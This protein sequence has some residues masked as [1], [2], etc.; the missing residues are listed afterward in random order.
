MIGRFKMG[1]VVM[2]LVMGMALIF[3]WAPV[4]WALEKAPQEVL[5]ARRAALM[6]RVK[7]GALVVFAKKSSEMPDVDRSPFRQ[8]DDFYYLTGWDL[9]LIHI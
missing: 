8:D 2:S 6:E 4:A 1:R 5:H 9:S 3:A 7:D